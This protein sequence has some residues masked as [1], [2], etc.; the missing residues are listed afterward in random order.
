VG[1]KALALEAKKTFLVD[2]EDVI[3]EA[4]RNGIAIVAV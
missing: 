3:K 4:D 2:M 1:G